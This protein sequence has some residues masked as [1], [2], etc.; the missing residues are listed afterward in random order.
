VQCSGITLLEA[1]WVGSVVAFFKK[2][3]HLLLKSKYF[4]FLKIKNM[5]YALKGLYLKK[6][7]PHLSPK[8]TLK[9]L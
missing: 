9:E 6:K 2:L 5:M 4:L 1:V 7:L 8:H 3:P